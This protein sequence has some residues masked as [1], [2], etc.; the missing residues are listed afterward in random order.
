MSRQHYHG[1]RNADLL[2]PRIEHRHTRFVVVASIAR[3]DR[4][5]MVNGCRGDEE[6]RLAERVA[7]LPAF[8]NQ[9]PPLEHNVL[10]DRK[11]PLVEHG[12]D[13][14]RE[15]LV[16]LGAAIGFTDKLYAKSNLGKSDHADMELLR[17]AG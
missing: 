2:F 13:L 4:E 12:T 16:Q 7:G 1:G 8:F 3:N 14:V 17:A 6:V 15:P 9:Y 10:G 11:N 5:S